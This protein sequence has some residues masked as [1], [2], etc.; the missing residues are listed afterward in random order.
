MYYLQS[1]ETYPSYQCEGDGVISHVTGKKRC[2]SSLQEP[3]S[4][5]LKADNV[6]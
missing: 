6:P 5:N 1:C 3:A 4:T 2:F